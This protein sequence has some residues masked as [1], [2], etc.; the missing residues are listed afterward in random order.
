MIVK[1]QGALAISFQCMLISA[2]ISNYVVAKGVTVSEGTSDV[3]DGTNG[4]T[5]K[6]YSGNVEKRNDVVNSKLGSGDND[7][8]HTFDDDKSFLRI[9]IN[10]FSIVII[11][12][13]L[14]LII[15]GAYF[16]CICCM[17]LWVIRRD[18]NRL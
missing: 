16:V 4:T 18:N 13:L 5:F 10:T 14:I 12:I 6:N 15:L 8:N 3:G 1:L 11:V 9:P 17:S 2:L 7:G